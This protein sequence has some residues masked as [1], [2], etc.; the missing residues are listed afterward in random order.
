MKSKKPKNRGPAFDPRGQGRTDDANAFFPDPDGG[1]AHV[2]DDLAESLAEDFVQSAVS[3][4]EGDERHQDEVVPEELGGP[5][6]ETTAEEEFAA[7]SDDSNPPDGDKEAVP[8]AVAGIVQRP[9][10]D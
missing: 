2:S 9:E 8:T 3:G 6:V 5:F 7:G 10:E 1:P 4:Q